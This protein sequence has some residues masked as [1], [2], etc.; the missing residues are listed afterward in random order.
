MCEDD[1]CVIF[2]HVV[3]VVRTCN[4]THYLQNTIILSQLWVNYVIA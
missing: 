2:F 3:E 1:E 4:D